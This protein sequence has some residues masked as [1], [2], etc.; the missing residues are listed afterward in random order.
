MKINVAIFLS[1]M[2]LQ[3]VVFAQHPC[4]QDDAY[5]W[6]GK[7]SKNPDDLAMADPTFPKAQFP[8]LLKRSD[9]VIALLK[10]AIPELAGVDARPYRAIRGNPYVKD[11]PVMFGVDIPV[12]GYDCVPQTSLAPDLRGKILVGK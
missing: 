9:Q 5:K 12:F 2:L 10:Q 11:G 7:W 8:L 6:P 3:T 1:L 4:T